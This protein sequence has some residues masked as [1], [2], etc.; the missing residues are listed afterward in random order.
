M[1]DFSNERLPDGSRAVL[2]RVTYAKTDKPK[3]TCYVMFF[4]NAQGI[5]G[6]S[7]RVYREEWIGG[8]SV[9]DYFGEGVARQL[10]E[11]TLNLITHDRRM[12]YFSMDGRQFNFSRRDPTKAHD[13]IKNAVSVD[14]T[15]QLGFENVGSIKDVVNIK[16]TTTGRYKATS[17]LVPNR[18]RKESPT[19][20][21]EIV[22]HFLLCTRGKTFVVIRALSSG[23][24]KRIYEEGS[25][26][27]LKECFEGKAANRIF[28]D[29]QQCFDKGKRTFSSRVIAMPDLH[30]AKRAQYTY[31]VTPM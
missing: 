11:S 14:L 27:P 3:Q 28:S 15:R 16:G 29:V 19:P 8:C 26:K 4:F 17:E 24:V 7:P 21:L 25:N 23:L 18:P 20:D 9:V 6:G 10:L 12:S 13:W 22:E 31:N 2:L 5:L 30:D 1:Y